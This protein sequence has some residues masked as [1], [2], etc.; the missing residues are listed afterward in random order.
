VV[1]SLF[2]DRVA[3]PRA[4]H[5]R[6][7]FFARPPGEAARL[8]ETLAD[9]IH[10]A[11][12]Q[13]VIHRDLKP[14]N[15]LLVD[16]GQWTVDR[17]EDLSS[18]STVHCPL[19]TLVPK[20]TDFGLAKFLA[21]GGLTHSGDVL[22]TPSY[23][24]PEQAAGR[25]EAITA[26]VD[27]YGLGAIL[28][29]AL[30]GRPPFAAARADATLGQVRRDE[31][32]PPRRLQPT[33]P[34]DLDTI[35]LKCLRKEAARRYATAQELA[36]DLRRFRAG[37]PVR[38]R[39]VGTGERVVV[40]CRRNPRVAGLLA[41]LVLVFLAGGAGVLWQWQRASRNAAEAEQ[42]AA[43]FRRQRD[44]A[45]QEKERA[46]R[47]LHMVRQRVDRLNRL[48]RELLARP[49]AYRTGQAVLEEALAFYQELLPEE[50]NDP[51]V[52]R[53]AAE[54]FRQVAEIH[55][56]RGQWGKAAEA[57]GRQAGLLTSLLEEDPANKALRI[58]LADAHRWRG[59]ALRDLGQV[60][61]AREAYGRA[62]RLHEELLRESPTMSAI[63]WHSPTPSSTRP[64]SFRAR[65]SPTS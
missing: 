17:Q 22:G 28:Y 54:L 46:E 23:M 1:K 47:H 25:S 18:P 48:G 13:G 20:I 57:Y 26:A 62:A 42:N 43:A 65:T 53:E 50:G 56:T 10:Y 30:T 52:R 39:P 5:A 34:H 49:G 44:T 9:A 59:N 21:G 36:D 24:A 33:V 64:P 45:R 27:I 58:E 8:V 29:E 37:E 3:R 63:R 31:P 40:W 6:R 38:A 16:S 61:E 11:H 4:R 35:C 51:S 55:H 7:F 15:V 2:V 41:A 60:S 19:S 14:A 32:V 12:Q